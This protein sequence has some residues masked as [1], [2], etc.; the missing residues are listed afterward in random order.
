MVSD[1]LVGMTSPHL[2]FLCKFLFTAAGEF[3]SASLSAPA[4]GQVESLRLRNGQ[5][6]PGKAEG[7]AVAGVCPPGAAC[8]PQHPAP[9]AQRSRRHTGGSSGLQGLLKGGNAL[10]TDLD[11]FFGKSAVIG[12]INLHLVLLPISQCCGKERDKETE[13]GIA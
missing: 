13:R 2:V 7:S 3:A 8:P 11:F 10:L 9:A 12:M 1:K 4:L 6:P 5:R